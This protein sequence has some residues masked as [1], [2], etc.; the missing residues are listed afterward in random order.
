MNFII[1]EISLGQKWE[2][3]GTKISQIIQMIIT[4]INGINFWEL[5]FW[6]MNYFVI[7]K[8]NVFKLIAFPLC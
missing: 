4:H 7:V 1:E 2:V 6:Y 8:I 5:Y 3:T